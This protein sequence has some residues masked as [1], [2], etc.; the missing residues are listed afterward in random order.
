MHVNGVHKKRAGT[1]IDS[2]YDAMK[3]D[4]LSAAELM[5]YG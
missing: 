5:C 4:E 1:K 2:P 3:H